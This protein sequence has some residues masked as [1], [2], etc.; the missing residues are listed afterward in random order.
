MKKS[1][2][3]MTIEEIIELQKKYQEIS[4]KN[5]KDIELLNQKI[6]KIR[7]YEKTIQTELDLLAYELENRELREYK[8]LDEETAPKIENKE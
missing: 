2:K 5:N 3:D 6:A 4:T 7:K 8:K 1:R